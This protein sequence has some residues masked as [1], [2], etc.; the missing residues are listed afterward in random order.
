MES[1]PPPFSAAAY[2]NEP[3]SYPPL[4][5][6]DLAALG[7][8][9]AEEYRNLVVH[10]INQHCL[11]LAVFDGTYPWHQHPGSDELF[12]VVDGCLIIDLAD[13][14]SLR[15][16]PWQA[17]TVPAGTVHR[18]RTEGR[19]VNLCFEMLGA[20]TVFTDDEGRGR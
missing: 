12:L 19:T 17:A 18:T 10:Q 2:A 20:D 8:G 13:G 14:K 9:I 4:Q 11:R 3:V 16:G 5:V 7:A 6:V 1:S 15:L